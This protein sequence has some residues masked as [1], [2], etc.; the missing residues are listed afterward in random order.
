MYLAK[1]RDRNAEKPQTE[2]KYKWKNTIRLIK[3]K[4]TNFSIRIYEVEGKIANCK[5][6]VQ[7]LHQTKICWTILYEIQQNLKE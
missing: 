3:T 7:E 1:Q 6:N 5:D 2:M 4:W